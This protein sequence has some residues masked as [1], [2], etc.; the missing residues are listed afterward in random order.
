MMVA[1]MLAIG[2]A[3][4]VALAVFLCLIISFAP[5]LTGPSW[6]LR[7][8]VVAVALSVVVVSSSSVDGTDEVRAGQER[9]LDAIGDAL[10]ERDSSG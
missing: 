8:L 5:P 2:F 1:L 10:H 3:V 7:L 4:L 9:L 6:A